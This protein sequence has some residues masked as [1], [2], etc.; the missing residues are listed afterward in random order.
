MNL[1]NYFDAMLMENIKEL[2]T[3]KL[4]QI[5]KTVNKVLTSCMECK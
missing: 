2:K 4:Y 3:M 5:S 1:L